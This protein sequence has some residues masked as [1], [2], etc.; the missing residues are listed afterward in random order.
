MKMNRVEK[1]LVNSPARSGRVARRATEL[2]ELAQPQPGQKYLDVGCGNGWAAIAAVQ[3]YG[4]RVTGV[5][6]DPDQIRRAR[7][8]GRGTEGARFQTADATQ[9]PFD[10]REFDIV[11]TS[12]ATH[13]MA[14]WEEAFQEMAR[15]LKRGG[16]LIYS[17]F[18][19]PGRLAAG[20]QALFP[21]YGFPTRAALERLAEAGGLRPVSS[22]WFLILYEAV[23]RKEA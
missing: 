21:G 16:H 7:E 9:L 11:A 8:H 14:R 10:D 3:R 4:L 2:L 18:V 17:D 1:L 12:K 23:W 20:G 19:A 6:V 5:D 13:H 15:V 22:S